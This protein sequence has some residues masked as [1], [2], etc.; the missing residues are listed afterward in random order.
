MI[1]C[2]IRYYFSS[3]DRMMCF[4]RTVKFPSVPFIGSH[5][6]LKAEHLHVGDVIFCKEEPPVLVITT[7]RFAD[8]EAQDII[9][10]M[11]G[12]GWDIVSDSTVGRKLT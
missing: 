9:D 2:L 4:E 11:R 8:S 12:F 7:K 10:D 3:D 1:I 5:I 6:S